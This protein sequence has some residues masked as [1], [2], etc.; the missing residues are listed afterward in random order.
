MNHQDKLTEIFCIIDDFCIEFEK[1]IA[2]HTISAGKIKR[3]R[4]ARLSDSEIM[5]ILVFI[6]SWRVSLS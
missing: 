1:E 5:T 3:K 4:A 2:K 6:S